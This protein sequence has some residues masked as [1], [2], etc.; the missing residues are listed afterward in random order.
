[1]TGKKRVTRYEFLAAVDEVEEVFRGNR[2]RTKAT[3]AA[4]KIISGWVSQTVADA[5]AKVS[6]ILAKARAI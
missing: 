5:R 4:R 2:P 1:M 6:V 3:D